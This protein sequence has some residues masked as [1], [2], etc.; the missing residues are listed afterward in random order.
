MFRKEL[1]L[2]Y[3]ECK[4][5]WD[6]I[7]RPTQIRNPRATEGYGG[8]NSVF[9]GLATALDKFNKSKRKPGQTASGSDRPNKK[10]RVKQNYC[11]MYNTVGGCSNPKT[12]DGC[13]GG[14]GQAYRHGC[15]VR[16]QPG[17]RTCQSKSHNAQNHV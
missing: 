8:Y 13:V 1:P 3:E 10:P 14:D 17:N 2:T 5:K 15:S 9:K 11:Q 12:N 4:S 6:L 7:N 16:V